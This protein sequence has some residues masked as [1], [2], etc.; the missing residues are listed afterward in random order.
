[1]ITLFK[2]Q[3]EIFKYGGKTLLYCRNPPVKSNKKRFVILPKKI[4][5]K[6]D[7]LLMKS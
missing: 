3:N 5:N 7:L 4:K 1:M 6:K 2:K